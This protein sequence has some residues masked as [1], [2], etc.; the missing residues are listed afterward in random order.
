MRHF[1]TLSQLAVVR[2]GLAGIDKDRGHRR[3]ACAH[4]RESVALYRESPR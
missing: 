3:A 1:Q 2:L 4:Y